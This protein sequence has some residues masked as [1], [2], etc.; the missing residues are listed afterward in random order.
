MNNEELVKKALRTVKDFT[1]TCE[2]S[3]WQ[4]ESGG[5][6]CRGEGK[7]KLT[8]SE[9]LYLISEMCDSHKALFDGMHLDEIDPHER[10]TEIAHDLVTDE[11]KEGLN[12]IHYGGNCLNLDTYL[13]AWETLIKKIFDGEVNEHTL[14]DWLDF[15][16]G[17]RD[18]N[19]WSNIE[20][21]HD[22]KEYEES[23]D[24]SR[25]EG[26]ESVDEYGITHRED[27]CCYF[28]DE[29]EYLE[30]C[31]NCDYYNGYECGRFNTPVGEYDSCCEYISCGY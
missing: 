21:W 29:D 10:I 14:D 16:E 27:G 1:F 20:E 31:R 18:I 28:D 4:G 2:I 30:V 5:C 11:M 7:M 3:L 24:L 17:E 13:D 23:H 15:F 12:E 9:L 26:E 8:A 19:M 25:Y 22:D 6:I